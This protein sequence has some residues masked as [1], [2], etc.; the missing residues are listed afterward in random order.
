MTMMADRTKLRRWLVVLGLL[1]FSFAATAA[2]CD[3]DPR[4]ISFTFVNDTDRHITYV[5]AFAGQTFETASEG[6]T[7]IPPTLAPGEAT[8]AA[9]KAPSVV[10]EDGEPWCSLGRTY[11]FISPK[12][13]TVTSPGSPTSAQPP[14]DREAVDI[15]HVLD[16]PCWPQQSGNRYLVTDDQS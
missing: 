3:E 7:K 8:N 2:S 9:T 6:I 16:A 4:E 1:T 10:P 13:P 15:I 14:F 5:V 11:Y 12:D